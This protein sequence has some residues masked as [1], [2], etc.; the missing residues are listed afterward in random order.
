MV[1]DAGFVDVVESR[2]KWP[3]GD[4]PADPRLK[5]MGVLNARHWIEGLEGWTM[6]MLTKFGNVSILANFDYR[7]SRVWQIQSI[8]G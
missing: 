5:E 4:W 6:R 3:I 8:G 7:S 1:T 2:Y